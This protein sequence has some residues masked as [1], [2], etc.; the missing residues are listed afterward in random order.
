[1]KKFL[2]VFIALVSSSAFATYDSRFPGD[3]EHMWTVASASNRS[4][5]YYDR[6]SAART[7]AK[8]SFWEKEDYF[9]RSDSPLVQ[10]LS[11]RIV[12]CETGQMATPASLSLPNVVEVSE[13]KLYE[14]PMEYKSYL[15]GSIELKVISFVCQKVR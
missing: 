5:Y 4:V 9:D 15:P 14:W 6:A 1:M 12:N 3:W 13:K 10:T 11:H 2:F 8:V 7:G